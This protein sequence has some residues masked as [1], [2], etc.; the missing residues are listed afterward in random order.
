[1][2]CEVC[3]EEVNEAPNNHLHVC[4]RCYSNVM[5][6]KCAICGEQKEVPLV[7]GLCNKCFQLVDARKS[8]LGIDDTS[9]FYKE[10]TDEDAGNTTS[11][12]DTNSIDEDTR[13]AN[14]LMM[15]EIS[16]T[17][18]AEDPVY[19]WIF[20]YF[21]I[22]KAK[23]LND[24]DIFEKVDSE[25]IADIKSIIQEN[26]S[27]IQYERSLLVIGDNAD[28]YGNVLAHKGKCFFVREK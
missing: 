11:T 7:R 13:I 22:L 12:D 17:Q 16:P 21:H 25:V 2:L 14:M 28:N 8:N 24:P 19:N 20:I 10:Y 4:K 23:S 18:L 26:G 6:G 27:S 5:Q 15:G 1:M 9:E 3:F